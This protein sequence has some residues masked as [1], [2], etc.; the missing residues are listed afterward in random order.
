M[1]I[2]NSLAHD[3]FILLLTCVCC[4]LC[5]SSNGYRMESLF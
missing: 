2:V 5:V 1:S 3:Q 4:R